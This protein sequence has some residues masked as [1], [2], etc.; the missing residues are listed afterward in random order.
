[1]LEILPGQ[2]D[3]AG[4]VASLLVL[5]DESLFGYLTDGHLDTW[6]NLT[7]C[8]WRAPRGV[9]SYHWSSV[10][11]QAGAVVGVLVGY[12]AAEHDTI[13]W[14]FAAAQEHLPADAWSVIES[15]HAPTTF[16]FPEIPDGVFYVQNIAVAESSRGSGLGR[17]LMEAAFEKG[18]RAGCAAC[19]LDVD[20]STPAV[21]FYERLG[22]RALVRTEVLAL[23]G[24]PAHLRMVIDL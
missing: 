2:P 14:S 20:S 19:H 15:R 11:R 13:D 9:Y 3:D 4:S 10:A 16:L 7:A 8:E 24:I 12:T 5:S 6:R 18:R 1:V 23:P 22:M 21:H 17:R